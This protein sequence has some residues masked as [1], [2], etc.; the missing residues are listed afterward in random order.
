V[1]PKPVN[2]PERTNGKR[3]SCKLILITK[4]I[5]GRLND[6][7]GKE[8]LT[9]GDN[10]AARTRPIVSEIVN[11]NGG[12]T[13]NAALIQ[14]FRRTMWLILQNKTRS[15]NISTQLQLVISFVLLGMIL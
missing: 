3:K 11:Y 7:G 13:K 12:E 1:V 9:I 2:S 14:S 4:P 15:S 6:L 5:N 10:T 8:I